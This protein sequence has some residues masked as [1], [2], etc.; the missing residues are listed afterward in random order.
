MMI[1]KRLIVTVSGS[2]KYIA[3]N[4]MAQWCSLAA[5]IVMMYSITALFADVYNKTYSTDALIRT[6]ILIVVAA[7]V[8]GIFTIVSSKM[9]FLASKTVKK[10]LREA[11]NMITIPEKKKEL[12]YKEKEELWY[13]YYT[14]FD[15]E[16]KL[17]LLWYPKKTIPYLCVGK[18]GTY[19]DHIKINIDLDNVKVSSET[20]FILFVL[21][22]IGHEVGHIKHTPRKP[23]NYGLE[24]GPRVICQEISNILE[25]GK[26]RITDTRSIE[27][28]ITDANSKYH[29]KL[30]LNALKLLCH[31][32]QN[33]LEDG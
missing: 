3:G 22:L 8:R 5:N 2:K 25:G 19:T 26:R 20:E 11:L 32:I 27:S 29:L 9:S 16:V 4:V 21:Y 17:Q 33:S 12:S 23:W 18:G 30:S 10:T 7:I 28:F 24:E 31:T 6:A 1:N 15:A 13:K 14:T